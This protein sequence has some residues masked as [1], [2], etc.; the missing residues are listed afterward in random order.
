M[1]LKED[2]PVTAIDGWPLLHT[3]GTESRCARLVRFPQP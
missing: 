2:D 1:R 3:K